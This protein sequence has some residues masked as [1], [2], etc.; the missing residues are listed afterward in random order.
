[1]T[2]QRTLQ[3]IP[4]TVHSPSHY[5]IS[6]ATHA[7]SWI[8]LCAVHMTADRRWYIDVLMKRGPSV[9]RGP[10]ASR[11]EAIGAIAGQTRGVA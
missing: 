9:H 3:N 4:F 6:G 10:F 1:M 5:T 2:A 11:D 8:E 7:S